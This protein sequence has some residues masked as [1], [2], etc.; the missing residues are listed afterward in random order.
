[1]GATQDMAAKG[2]DLARSLVP[3]SRLLLTLLPSAGPAMGFLAFCP[4][5][6]D[7]GLPLGLEA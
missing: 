1:M 7:R 4:S 5:T 2:Q 3:C 6:G